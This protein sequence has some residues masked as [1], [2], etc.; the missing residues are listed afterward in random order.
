MLEAYGSSSDP[1]EHV[2]VF[3]AKMTLYGTS[4]AIICR[5]FLMT[6][7]GIARGWYSRLPPLIEDLIH[8]DHLDRYI[9]KL[10]EPSLHPKGPME[11]HINV[12]VEGPVVGGVSS[13][14]KKAYACAKVQKRPRPQ[15]DPGF[16]FESENEYPD[17]DD[18]LVVTAHI[19][20]ACVRRILIDIESFADILYFDAFHKLGMTNRDLIHMTSTLTGFTDDAITP[21]GV[22]TLH[23]TFDD[24]PRTKTLM[25]EVLN[26]HKPGRDQE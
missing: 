18:A 8:C 10:R 19:T 21:V 17:H 11:R 24:E 22:A 20:N 14:V 12:I 16:T 4:D 15:S 5:A 7:R 23:V 25:H 6:L 3:Y 2:A 1:T 9:R 26:Q 13:S